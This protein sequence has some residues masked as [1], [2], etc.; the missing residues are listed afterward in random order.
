MALPVAYALLLKFAPAVRKT[1]PPLKVLR[2]WSLSSLIL[3]IAIFL[4]FVFTDY[5][6]ESTMVQGLKFKNILIFQILIY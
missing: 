4:P 1:L 3:F 5:K 6:C 2:N